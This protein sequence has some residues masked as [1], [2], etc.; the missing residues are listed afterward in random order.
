M[1]LQTIYLIEGG[2]KILSSDNGPEF[3]NEKMKELCIRFNIEQRKTREFQI[4]Y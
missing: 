4:N 1:E 3:I 2:P